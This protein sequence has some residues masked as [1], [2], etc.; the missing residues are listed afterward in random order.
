MLMG[1]IGD[2][3]PVIAAGSVFISA[4]GAA[5]SGANSATAG[6][7]D[8]TGANLIVVMTAYDNSFAGTPTV[9]DSKSNSW[10]AL[11][12]QN[13]SLG[14]AGQLFYSNTTASPT[15]GTG[16]T[17]SI[18]GTNTFPAIVVATFKQ[19]VTSPF[20]Q[21]NGAGDLGLTTHPIGGSVTPGSNNEL[22]I[23]GCTY[24]AA[25]ATDT[26]SVDSGFTIAA[27]VAALVGTSY[28]CGLA[29]LK[30]GTL[31]AVN[32]TWTISLSDHWTCE[33]ATFKGT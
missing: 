19:A 1:M 15:V 28:G 12:R 7:L 17:F 9:A 2:K 32:P 6:S 13:A 26:V 27:H 11:Q 30:Q 8:S 21:Q 25:L 24:G 3:A 16:H 10:T 23:T 5:A 33:N 31:G 14:N 20:D 29:W 18:T 22:I 4:A